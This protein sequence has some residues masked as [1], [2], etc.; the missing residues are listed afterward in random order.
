MYCRNRATSFNIWFKWEQQKETIKQRVSSFLFS[1]FVQALRFGFKWEIR[2]KW[3]NIRK[4]I[5]IY[6]CEKKNCE[7]EI[8]RKRRGVVRVERAEQPNNKQLLLC[9][10]HLRV[11]KTPQISICYLLSIELNPFFILGNVLRNKFYIIIS[12]VPIFYGIRHINLCTLCFI[13]F[14]FSISHS[15][16]F[17]SVRSFVCSFAVFLLLTHSSTSTFVYSFG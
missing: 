8:S 5:Y 12:V 10:L 4:H 11:S 2:Q 14:D 17:S 7:W 6:L 3:G 9:F 16:S 1:V 13:L 15:F